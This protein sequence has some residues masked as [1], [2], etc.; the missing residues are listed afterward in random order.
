MLNNAITVDQERTAQCY[1]AFVFDV[2]RL[3]NAVF[4]IGNQRVTH[5]TNTTLFHRGITP[6]VVSKVTVN[7]H[8]NHFNVA[9]LEFFHAMVKCNQFRRTNK[10]EVQ[11]VEE[12]N[13]VFALGCS[14]KIVVFNNLTIAQY[15]SG[16]EIRGFFT[17]QNGHFCTPVVFKGVAEGKLSARHDWQ[18]FTDLILCILPQPD[19]AFVTGFKPEF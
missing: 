1:A 13:G 6:C 4:H 11:R 2:I 3:A 18:M 5:L 14:G 8:A 12:Y 15:G 17:N 10:G 9:L 7:R 19:M 16:S